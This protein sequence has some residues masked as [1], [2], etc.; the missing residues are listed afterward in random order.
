MEFTLAILLGLLGSLHCAA[1]CGPLQLALP[2][3][4]GGP[5]R[6]VAQDPGEEHVG[7][8]GE[9]HRRARVAGLGRPGGVD[10]E[11]PD[12]VDTELFPL[13]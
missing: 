9:G 13:G 2:V 11:A 3:P 10:G 8:G 5:R 6:I 7:Q 1:M 4:P 12:D